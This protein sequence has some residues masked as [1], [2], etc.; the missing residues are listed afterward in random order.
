MA[1][2]TLIH[3]FAI[4]DQIAVIQQIAAPGT[5]AVDIT[6]GLNYVNM[7]LAQASGTADKAC[8]ATRNTTDHTT[9]SNGHVAVEAEANKTVMLLS[10]GK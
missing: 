9:V 8:V 1:T 2:T 6:T 3:Q 10:I 7:A 4:G 5:N